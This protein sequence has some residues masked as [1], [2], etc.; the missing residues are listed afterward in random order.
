MGETCS[1]SQK[2]KST[3]N[4]QQLIYVDRPPRILFLENPDEE[5]KV[6]LPMSVRLVDEDAMVL[7]FLIMT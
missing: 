3:H 2:C 4:Y 7:I 5:L 6:Y 1:F